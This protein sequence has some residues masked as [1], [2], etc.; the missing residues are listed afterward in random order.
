MQNVRFQGPQRRTIPH[1]APHAH[2]LFVTVV[3]SRSHWAYVAYI[4]TIR[5]P[6]TSTNRFQTR[7]LIRRWVNS[8]GASD[9]GQIF[10]PPEIM[11]GRFAAWNLA[12]HMLNISEGHMARHVSSCC[13]TWSEAATKKMNSTNSV[14]TN[15]AWADGFQSL[16]R[17][18]RTRTTPS[19]PKKGKFGD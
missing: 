4:R 1:L 16:N 9:A 8:S 12:G 3:P 14:P 13:R 5:L 15:K 2:P 17:S 10:C 11:W 6:R 18:Y 7:L 19:S